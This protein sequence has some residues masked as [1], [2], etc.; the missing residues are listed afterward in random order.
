MNIK[1]NS[2]LLSRIRLVF[3]I[4]LIYIIF[5]LFGAGCPIKFITGISS[6]GCGMTRAVWAAL[7]FR[8]YEAFYY[9]PLFF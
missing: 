5:S 2:Q 3:L 8:F 9:H 7:S 1:A 4:L 6:P